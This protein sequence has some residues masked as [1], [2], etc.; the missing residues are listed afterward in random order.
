MRTAHIHSIIL[1]LLYLIINNTVASNYYLSTSLGD[2]SRTSTQAKNMHTPWKTLTKLNSSMSILLPGDSVLLKRGDVFY[3]SLIISKSGTATLPIS[4][5]DYGTGAKPEING[6]SSLSTWINQGTNNWEADCT[7]CESSL[8]NLLINKIPQQ[9]GR[10]PNLT[11]TNKGYLIF[12]SHNSNTQITDNQLTAL[13]NWTGA[14]VVV[15]TNH[16]VIENLPIK[17][18]SGNTITYKGSTNYTPGNNWGYFFQKSPLTLDKYG[19]WYF[20]PSTKKV[21][22]YTNSSNPS[23]ISI[24]I[25]TIGNLLLLNGNQ[26]INIKNLNLR[27]AN[28]TAIDMTNVKSI[29]ITD[30]DISESGLN[31]IRASNSSNISLINNRITGC[32]NNALYLYLNCS[33]SLISNN[34]IQNTGLIP[35]SGG[36]GDDA[37]QA[38]IV[39]G[40]NNTIEYN[41]I[42]S[43]GYV[44]IRFEGDNS[45]VKYNYISNYLLTKDD[46]GGIYTWRGCNQTGAPLLS[47]IVG[48][49][50]TNAVGAAEGTNNDYSAVYGIYMDDNV[51]NIEISGNTI[52]NIKDGGI[53]LHNSHEITL[54]NNTSFNNGS[55]LHAQYNSCP[56][57]VIRNISFN[58]NILFAKTASQQ[59]ID[60]QTSENDVN[61]FGS[62]DNNYYCRPVSEGFG[63][64]V[65]SNL[66]TLSQWQINFGKDPNS[67]TS[68]LT[69]PSYTENFLLGNN[70]Y[71]NGNFNTNISGSYCWSPM[72]NCI[73]SWDN[74]QKLDNGSLKYYFNSVSGNSNASVLII[75]IGRIDM[76]KKYSL[77][78]SIKGI[79]NNQT[80]SAN[81]RQNLTPYGNLT[82]I[83][84]CNL[85]T[86]RTENEFILSPNFS[87]NDACIQ[88]IINEA[89][90]T[91]WIDNIELYEVDV[92]LTNLDDYVKYYYNATK[93]SKT[94]PL[95]DLYIDVKGNSFSDAIE[96]QPFSS[97]ILLKKM[98]TTKENQASLS[99]ENF[100]SVY[101]NPASESVTIKFESPTIE[102]INL[103]LINSLG[104]QILKNEI[105]IGSILKNI[106][107]K[108]IPSGTY[109]LVI[110]G[111]QIITKKKLIIKK[112][113]G[114]KIIEVQEF[115]LAIKTTLEG[116]NKPKVLIKT[117]K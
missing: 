34:N 25:S 90:G 106:I 62:F 31:G 68:P 88:F 96:L 70:K 49:I 48:N 18:H 71:N 107:L 2:D 95:N 82:P 35:G 72:S 61:S 6:L 78:F 53:F 65:N 33:N 14:E 75:A 44:P 63:F 81:L 26:Y 80:I 91:I 54:F 28:S 4:F 20:N 7:A 12:E 21:R 27:G 40:N 3:G 104:Q 83:Q 56:L 112:Q 86:N 69:I 37:Y 29:T 46:G 98:I 59:I 87:E 114:D 23:N 58:N 45:S 42:D 43:T 101:P 39:R 109:I 16:W 85:S 41:T 79:N 15:R 30:C 60:I 84:S 76:Q 73:I 52:T 5:S 100:I 66:Y 8:N 24:E 117:K 105:Q 10:Y 113:I 22:V 99:A 32:K 57:G 94:V 1:L 50:I 38:I 51:S 77:K 111:K 47:K 13:P 55:Q 89:V 92:T 67:K 115:E 36:S 9:I 74:T 102:L 110:Y 19:E 64:K 97:T 103:E 116:I 11:D 17:L 108:S 93:L